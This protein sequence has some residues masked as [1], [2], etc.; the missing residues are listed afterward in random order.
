M[1]TAN[2]KPAVLV[3]V[4]RQPESNTLQVANEVHALM[5][6]L[7]PGLPPGVHLEPFYDQSTIV[8]DSIASVRDA[9]LIGIL[10]S[11]IILVLFLRD[12][13][14]SLVAGLVI[15]ITLLITFIVLNMTNQTF[16]LMTF[17]GLPPSFALPI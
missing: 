11:S 7:A 9:V 3:N 13:G 6:E 1:V 15:P 4:N 14:T 2:G 12:C 10:L 16:S 17:G 5:Q 8:H